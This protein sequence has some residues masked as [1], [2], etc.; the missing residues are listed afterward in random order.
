MALV[1]AP[2][3]HGLVVAAPQGPRQHVLDGRKRPPDH[4]PQQAPD[5]GDRQG[6]EWD[7]LGGGE[8]TDADSW[9][10]VGRV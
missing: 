5:F 9:P 1:V 3:G 7:Q 8:G 10:A 6:N 4:A 2:L